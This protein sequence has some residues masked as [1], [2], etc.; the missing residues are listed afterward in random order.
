MTQ[1]ALSSVKT[2]ENRLVSEGQVAES[3]ATS[4]QQTKEWEMAHSIK[5]QMTQNTNLNY[6]CDFRC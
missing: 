2:E 4:L 6:M 5:C 1:G 3:T